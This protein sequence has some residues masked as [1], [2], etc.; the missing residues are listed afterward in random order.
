MKNKVAGIVFVFGSLYYS[1]AELISA[2]FFK[3]SLINTYLLSSL[4]LN[5]R[6]MFCRRKL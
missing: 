1:M 3:D 4:Y 5:M 2:V 6:C